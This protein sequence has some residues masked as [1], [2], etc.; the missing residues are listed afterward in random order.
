MI[1][2]NF[3]L[4]R[5]GST[6]APLSTSPPLWS[7]KIRDQSCHSRTAAAGTAVALRCSELIPHT[8]DASLRS[9][10]IP[11]TSDSSLRSISVVSAFASLSRCHSRSSSNARPSPSPS[12]LLRIASFVHRL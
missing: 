7:A 5:Y 1:C 10:L 8:S 2:C 12:P 11:H 9:V 3:C 6:T 4:P